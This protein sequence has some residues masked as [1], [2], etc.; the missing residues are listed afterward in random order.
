M[1]QEPAYGRVGVLDTNMLH[2]VGLYLRYAK[3]K[4]LFPW[5][6]RDGRDDL[7]REGMEDAARELERPDSARGAKERESLRIGF[8]VVKIAS[9]HDIALCYGPIS[10]LELLVGR[11]RGKAVVDAAREGVPD[12]MWS[13]LD[14]RE[15]RD[16]VSADAMQ[17]TADRIAEIG[18]WLEELGLA[19]RTAIRRDLA[20]TIE[21]AC[22]IVGGVYLEVG[23]SIVYASAI[24]AGAEI[25]FTGDGPL[26]S[27]VNRVQNPSDGG[28]AAEV[29]RFRGIQERLRH[30]VAV[31]PTSRNPLFPRAH[32]VTAGGTVNPELV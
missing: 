23:D 2:Y 27:T 24:L 1:S 16:R 7:D 26:R 17:D 11:V 22:E 19:D 9:E 29:M 21:L 3:E 10:H 5:R 4:A 8:G 6:C 28:S 32:T 15:I 18:E 30:R 20:D 14:E 12:R 13:R 31:D 25:L